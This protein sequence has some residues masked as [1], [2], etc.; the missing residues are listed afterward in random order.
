MI[1]FTKK[2]GQP[3]EELD[4]FK[5]EKLT[6]AVEALAE[7]VIITDPGG[8][9]TYVNPAFEKITGYSSGEALGKNPRILKSGQ[10]PPERY[11]EMWNILLKGEVWR[12]RVI[13]KCK[14]GSLYHAELTI[15]PIWSN[16][17]RILSYVA[18]QHEVTQQLKLEEQARLANEEYKVLHEV[19]KALHNAE[20]IKEMLNNAMEAITKFGELEVEYKAGVFIADEKNR[21]LRLITTIGQFSDEFMEKDQEVPYG[22]CLCGIVAESGELLVSDS[23]FSD[24]RHT[25]L[26][27]DMT[28]HGHYIVPL[29]SRDKLIGI[30]F[31]Y[32]DE[33]PPWYERSQE[34]LLSIGDLIADAIEHKCVEEKT[35]KQ[36][37]ELAAA[38]SKLK[39]LN[40]LKNKFLG[41]ASHDLRA[42]LY[43]IRAYSE[44]LKEE[45][46][47]KIN[48]P[49]K[50]LLEKIH[51]S[52]EFMKNLLDNLLDIS[53][54]ESGKC[55]LDKKEEDFNK[56]AE[57]QIELHQLIAQKKGIEIKYDLGKIPPLHCDRNAII[58]I[59]GNFIGNAVKF[60]PANTQ[61]FVSTA[62]EGEN[63]RFSVKDEGPGISREE[64]KLL[65][66]EFQTL[67]SKPTGGEKSTGLGLAIVK[68]LVT[69]H[70]GEVGVSSE[71]GKGSTF[72]FKLPLQ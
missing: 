65:F 36:N 12:G 63:A 48:D 49:Q 52:S 57:S 46:I 69:L 67:S 11:K 33:N 16:S 56:L 14:N 17:G 19:A 54:I 53:K 47:G 71:P 32:T 39:E 66:G 44:V 43:L 31:L 5:S 45:S 23:C 42:P 1:G 37:Q 50:K 34:I 20:G 4:L 21:V 26:F 29:K 28:A 2:R 62:R 68:K 60:S 41:I 64:Q 8:T 9:I 40:E 27:Q 30:M 15:S 7:A 22:D 70:G 58:Q 38:N 6:K 24:K 59:M 25:R 13:N 18:V 35:Q 72:F 10:N 51:T 61:V 55:D 3:V